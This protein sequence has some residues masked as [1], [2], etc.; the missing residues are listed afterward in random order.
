MRQS[1]IVQHNFRRKLCSHL[2]LLAVHLY[3]ESI[4]QA[5]RCDLSQKSA[6]TEMEDPLRGR[7]LL[8]RCDHGALHNVDKVFTPQKSSEQWQLWL[9]HRAVV[10]SAIGWPI[11]IHLRLSP[12]LASILTD[13]ISVIQQAR[14]LRGRHLS[15]SH[16]SICPVFPRFKCKL[17]LL[18]EYDL[19]LGHMAA[20]CSTIRK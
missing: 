17:A 18:R 5:R 10:Y 16:V 7:N 6:A 19:N 12:Q 11:T 13:V 15:S 8:V 4:S 1:G 2:P 3:G 9:H 14:L 20:K